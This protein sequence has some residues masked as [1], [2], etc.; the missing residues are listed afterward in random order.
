[1]KNIKA[2]KSTI[3]GFVFIGLGIYLI[4]MTTDYNLYLVGSLLTGG[5]LLFFT[6]DR[7][8]NNLEKLVFNRVFFEQK[9][10]ESGAEK[11]E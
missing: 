8:I 9:A 4:T 2:F 1:M 6:G 11:G 10:G 3:L 5:T 7:F